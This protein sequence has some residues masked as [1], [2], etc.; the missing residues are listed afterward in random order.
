MCVLYWHKWLLFL[1]QSFSS[2]SLL[3]EKYRNVENTSDDT[4]LFTLLSENY[5]SDFA[6]LSEVGYLFLCFSQRQNVE[7]LNNKS[8]F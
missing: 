8:L 5:V 7:K 4:Q 3:P 2:L 1:N 6:K